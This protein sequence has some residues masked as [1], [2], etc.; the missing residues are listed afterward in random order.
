MPF[1]ELLKQLRLAVEL[2]QSGLARRAGICVNCI[3]RLEQ[4]EGCLPS[5]RNARRLA[6]ALGVPLDLLTD[7]SELAE[8][9]TLPV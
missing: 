1:G 7:C 8:E 5:V 9:E 4:G 2:S 3:R 6:K